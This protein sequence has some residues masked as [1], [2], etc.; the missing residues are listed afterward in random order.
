M[1]ID[2]EHSHRIGRWI[3]LH[4]KQFAEECM[5]HLQDFLADD[6]MA[7]KAK[8]PRLRTTYGPAYAV[9]KAI[10]SIFQ[11]DNI[12]KVLDAFYK[13]MGD[14]L[15]TASEEVA[16]VNFATKFWDDITSLMQRQDSRM[17]HV[18]KVA[19]CSF[20]N[21][22]YKPVPVNN[23]HNGKQPDGTAPCV[24]IS[25]KAAHDIYAA[26]KR[27]RG[28]S[29]ELSY[30]NLFSQLQQ[31][32]AWVRS[33]PAATRQGHR[34]TLIPGEDRLSVWVIRIDLMD[35]A[36]QQVFQPLIE[37]MLEPEPDDLPA[38]DASPEKNYRS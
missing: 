6:D 27:Q 7:K 11:I 31:Q 36:T 8:S 37:T 16:K 2:S 32:N 29:P 33:D 15:E 23:P 9:F 3:M 38:Y 10:N 35:E 5:K 22:K 24:I 17:S 34:M 28:E 12:D 4:R 19:F 30:Q 21:G 26:D 1:V 25:G 14:Y 18:V 13:F 20:P